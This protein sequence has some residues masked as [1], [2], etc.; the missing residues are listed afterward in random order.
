MPSRYPSY[1]TCHRRFQEWVADGTLEAIVRALRRDLNARGGI[2][3]IEGFIDGT[4]VPAKKGDPGSESAVQARQPRSWQWQTAMVFHSLLL[5]KA[6]NDMTSFSPS[7]LSMLLSW[8]S[9][10][11]D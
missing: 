2:E 11:L 9:S 5:L 10:P 3:D 6:D 8:M 1:S 4:Y 7:E